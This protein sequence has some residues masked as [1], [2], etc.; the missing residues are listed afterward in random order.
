[1]SDVVN[2]EFLSLKEACEWASSY[3]GRRVTL[4]NISYL[5]QYAKIHAYNQE[6]NLKTGS[7]GDARVSLLEL[8]QYYDRSEKEERWKEVLGKDINWNLSFDKLREAERTK[9]V[10][11]LH[12]Y[13]GKF[14]PQ[15]VEYFLD[16]HTNDFKKAVFFRKGDIVLDPFVGSRYYVGSML[17]IRV[18]LNRC[19]YFKIQL[20]DK[21]SQDTKI[22]FG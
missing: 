17:G 3:L 12:P 19:R 4:S 22:R 5:I 15:L 20:Y 18:T 16:D 6:G 1:M 9:H 21:R 10:H 2:K 7:N 13:K 8:K 11:R 14:I